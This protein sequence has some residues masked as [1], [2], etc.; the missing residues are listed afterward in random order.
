[1]RSLFLFVD[2]VI[3]TKR[4][5]ERQLSAAFSCQILGFEVVVGVN[6]TT[7]KPALP[8]SNTAASKTSSS[9]TGARAI[10]RSRTNS[11]A[12]TASSR[13]PTPNDMKNMDIGQYDGGFEIENEK[14]GST[15][16]GEAAEILALDSSFHV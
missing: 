3:V 5:V 4:P 12:T 6:S 9:T 11:A 14:R 15:V 13:V 1:M 16:S 7:T 8:R 10:Q 2:L